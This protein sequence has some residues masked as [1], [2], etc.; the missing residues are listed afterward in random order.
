MAGEGSVKQVQAVA[1]YFISNLETSI[2]HHPENSL[3]AVKPFF[4]AVL[5]LVCG[6][7]RGQR[8]AAVTELND[9]VFGI[10]IIAWLNICD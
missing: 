4:F 3:V 8:V 7:Q 10:S 6:D 5:G 9:N 1:S 2:C